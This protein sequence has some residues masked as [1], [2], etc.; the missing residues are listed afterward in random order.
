MIEYKVLFK[1]DIF[2]PVNRVTTSRDFNCSIILY[3]SNYPNGT[4]LSDIALEHA[5]CKINKHFWD[6][7]VIPLSVKVEFVQ[8]VEKN[9]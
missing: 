4:H 7:R 9:A 8:E 1:A 6:S 3:E 5:W 2:D